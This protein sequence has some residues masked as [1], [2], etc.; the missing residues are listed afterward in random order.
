MH[1]LVIEDEAAIANFLEHGLSAEGYSVT[2]V[3]DGESGRRRALDEEVDLVILDRMLPGL[4]GLQV[5]DAIRRVKPGLPVIVLTAR[6]EIDERVEGLD[7]GATDYLTKPFAFDELAA[8]VRAHL[9]QPE[10]SEATSLEVADV[11][12]DL[13]SREVERDGTPIHLSAKEFDLLAYLMRH[14]GQVLSREQILAAVWGYQHDPETNVVQVYVGYL[15]RRLARSGSPAPIETVRSV[16]YRLTR[17]EPEP[18][19]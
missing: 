17:P 10:Q 19:P 1:I 11:R 6:G 9:R 15:R 8:R 16:G 2:C 14:P 3:G 18:E 5:L 7:R 13:L 4:E 12:L